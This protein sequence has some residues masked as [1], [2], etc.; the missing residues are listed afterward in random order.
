[1]PTIRVI[2]LTYRRPHLLARALRGLLAQTFRDW[3]CELHND[4]P[5]DGRPK[6]VLDSVAPGDARFTYVRH[7]ETWGATRCFNYCFNAGPEP[8]ISLLEDDNWWEPGLLAT[9]Q[10][11][12]SS[13]PRLQLV[14]SNMRLW[15]EERDGGWTNTGRVIWPHAPEFRQFEWPVVLQAFDAI[16]SN[17]PMLFRSAPDGRTSIPPKTPFVG[18]ESVRERTIDRIG[19]V[20][21]PLANFAL[22]L[23]TARDQNRVTWIETRLRLA[24]SFFSTVPL[25]DDAWRDTWARATREQRNLLLLVAVAGVCRGRIVRLAGPLDILLFLRSF[26]GSIR[27]NVRG[28]RFRTTNRAIWDWILAHSAQRTGAA[29]SRGWQELGPGSLMRKTDP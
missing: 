25:S 20:G 8:F 10:S 11:R 12:I 17:G 29:R 9:L 5:A 22:T 6:E 26:F 24:C 4:D 7:G 3:V 18:V 15:Q 21:E 16:H 14:F 28:L 2:L 27:A 13:D 23:S 19:L 1:M